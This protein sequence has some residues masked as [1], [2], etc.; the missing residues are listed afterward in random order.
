MRHGYLDLER[1]LAQRVEMEMEMEMLLD[2]LGDGT[3]CCGG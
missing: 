1:L 3:G 2:L